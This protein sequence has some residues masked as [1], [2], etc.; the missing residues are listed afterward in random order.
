MWDIFT[1]AWVWCGCWKSDTLSTQCAFDVLVK[2]LED[3]SGKYFSARLK[4]LYTI[5]GSSV[6]LGDG[7]SLS[8][9]SSAVVVLALKIGND[10][11]FSLGVSGKE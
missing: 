8:V 4:I 7:F 5:G 10:G 6:R 11:R 3:R 2:G 1:Q 9:S